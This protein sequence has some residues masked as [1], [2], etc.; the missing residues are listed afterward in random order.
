VLRE[1]LELRRELAGARGR[2]W[3]GRHGAAGAERGAR[4][5]TGRAADSWR[6]APGHDARLPR[7]PFAPGSPQ[8]APPGSAI[9]PG[10]GD[11][12][13]QAPGAGRRFTPPRLAG[14]APVGPGVGAAP[15]N[16]PANA[17]PLAP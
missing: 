16:P 15:V 13:P 2:R 9:P 7:H 5:A 11:T 8:G 3:H 6:R 12:G 17:D 4:S 10:G 14:I 1:V